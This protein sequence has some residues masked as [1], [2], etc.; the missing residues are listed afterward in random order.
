MLDDVDYQEYQ[1]VLKT[2][3]PSEAHGLL[4]AYI[5][6]S[7][8][9]AILIWIKE[10]SRLTNDGIS[11]G[12]LLVHLYKETV[13]SLNDLNF[14]LELLLPE[15]DSFDVRMH[16]LQQWAEGFIYGVGITGLKLEG[17]GFEFLNDLIE[18]ARMPIEEDA[19]TDDEENQQDLEEVLE[20][21]RM[22]VMLVYHETLSE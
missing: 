20:F 11:E 5:C 16:G 21:I 10:L 9:D 14:T 8:K 19:E 2:V 1:D 7:P 6:A 22:G 18:F 3:N 17:D 13:S 15:D 4:L 12:D